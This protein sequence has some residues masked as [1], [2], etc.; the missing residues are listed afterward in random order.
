MKTIINLLIVCSL[1][2]MPAFAG[3]QTEN[4]GIPVLP[5]PSKIVIDG[6][7]DDWDLT[8]GIFA[9]DNVEEQRDRHSAWLHAMYDQDNLY[10]LARVTG[11]FRHSDRRPAGST[12]RMHMLTAPGTPQQLQPNLTCARDLDGKE[13]ITL[14][15]EPPLQSERDPKQMGAEQVFRNDPDGKGYT[16][17]IRIPLKVITSEGVTLGPGSEM[18]VLFILP[19]G[20]SLDAWDCFMPGVLLERTYWGTRKLDQFGPATF[21]RSGKL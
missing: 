17:E 11:S 21:E 18:R 7:F 3:T 10:V 13:S 2:A 6:R 14:K 19:F 5:V 12:L 8:G 1:L 4:Y 16:Q 20:W 9:C 15:F